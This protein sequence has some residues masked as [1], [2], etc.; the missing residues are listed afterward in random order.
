M[1]S[2]TVILPFR[3]LDNHSSHVT[4]FG[5]YPIRTLAGLDR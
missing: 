4:R 3:R 2:V 5:R 1:Q